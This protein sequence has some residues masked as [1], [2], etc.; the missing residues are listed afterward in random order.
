MIVSWISQCKV[1]SE[2]AFLFFPNVFCH[3]AET[4]ILLLHPCPFPIQQIND[5]FANTEATACT[6]RKSVFINNVAANGK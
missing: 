5:F 3:F 6:Y 1:T 4:S 2:F